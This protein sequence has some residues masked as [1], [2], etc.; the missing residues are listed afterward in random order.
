MLDQGKSSIMDDFFKQ[1]SMDTVDNS[2]NLVSYPLKM[3]KSH[4]L[5][6]V[7]ERNILKM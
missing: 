1:A 4:G 3:T 7:V 5:D 6:R 2:P